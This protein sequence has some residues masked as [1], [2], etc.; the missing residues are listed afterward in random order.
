MMSSSSGTLDSATA[1]HRSSRNAEAPFQALA[2]ARALVDAYERSP[3]QVWAV[4]KKDPERMKAYARLSARLLEL[5]ELLPL[6]AGDVPSP[7]PS[8]LG[9]ITKSMNRDLVW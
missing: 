1:V 3:W 9:R 8:L 6:S 5:E 4:K 7:L 2:S